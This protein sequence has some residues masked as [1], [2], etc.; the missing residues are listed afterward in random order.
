MY[1]NGQDFHDVKKLRRGCLTFYTNRLLI[2]YPP[3]APVK[4][5]AR[6]SDTF[7]VFIKSSW[8]IYLFALSDDSETDQRKEIETANEIFFALYAS[9]KVA[10]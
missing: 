5:L 3:F 4:S 6:A 10:Q 1:P 9:I 2:F 7:L 8:Q